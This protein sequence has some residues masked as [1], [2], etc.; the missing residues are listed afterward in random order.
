M[1]TG[2]DLD[3]LAPAAPAASEPAATAAPAADPPPAAIVPAA[4]DPRATSGRALRRSAL[5]FAVALALTFL[6]AKVTI[7]G[8]WL[9]FSILSLAYVVGAWFG[10]VGLARA[11]RS[12]PARGWHALL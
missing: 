2:S 6:A 1:V 12:T 10:L 4:L 3:V 8:D 5:V 9:T 7:H 11:L